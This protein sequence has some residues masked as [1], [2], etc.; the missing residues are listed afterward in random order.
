[1]KKTLHIAVL[2]VVLAGCSTVM[3]FLYPP[4]PEPNW[5]L[6]PYTFD[7]VFITDHTE[8]FANKPDL[9]KEQTFG[10]GKVR[11]TNLAKNAFKPNLYAQKGGQLFIDINNYAAQKE[12]LAYK[13]SM[14]AEF[15]AMV[16][17]VGILYQAPLSCALESDERVSVGYSE[18]PET[19]ERTPL[20]L[21]GLQTKAVWERLFKQCVEQMLFEVNQGVADY[22]RGQM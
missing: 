13:L 22:L 15:K 7:T 19:G 18:N 12:G 11:L 1:M 8:T 5:D 14:S 17:G 2:S 3:D 6:L 10:P 16:P 4:E 9:D 20:V 21:P